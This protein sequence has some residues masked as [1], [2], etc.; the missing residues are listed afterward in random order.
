MVEDQ[1]A[2][3][4]VAVGQARGMAQAGALMVA[5][6]N[7]KQPPLGRTMGSVITTLHNLLAHRE[8][9]GGLLLPVKITLQPLP[10]VSTL[11]EVGLGEV[12]VGFMAAAVVGLHKVLVE[13]EAATLQA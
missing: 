4:V 7:R 3:G 11:G 10:Q 9:G 5:H 13:V 12:V 6:R 2:G 1:A 8:E